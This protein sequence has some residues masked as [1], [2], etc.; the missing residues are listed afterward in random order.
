MRSGTELI[1][2]M[3]AALIATVGIGW[4]ISVNAD[5]QANVQG[6]G[7]TMITAYA[8]EK[9]GATARPTAP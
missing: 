9:A 7:I 3:L 1:P 8:A 4:L 5:A 2:I 6:A